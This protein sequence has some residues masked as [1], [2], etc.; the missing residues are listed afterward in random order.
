[1]TQA[2]AEEATGKTD[3]AQG[4]R[5]TGGKP[6]PRQEFKIGNL[7]AG[8]VDFGVPRRVVTA[9]QNAAEV[10]AALSR[11]VPPPGYGT[12]VDR[13]RDRNVVVIEG[14][15][16]LGRY[17]GAL[18]LLREVVQGDVLPISPTTTLEELHTCEY[19]RGRGYYVPEHTARE[20]GP[21]AQFRWNA[22]CSSVR[23]AGA[24]L[25]ITTTGA[26]AYAGALPWQR[27]D[28]GKLLR[29]VLGDSVDA[30]PADVRERIPV[31]WTPTDIVAFGRRL[32]DGSGADEALGVFDLTATAD[33]KE[34]FHDEDR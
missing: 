28:L 2:E 21:E 13:L 8:N 5:T 10:D 26:P 19:E 11:Y 9:L 18:A 12:A 23:T 20:S 25:V 14:R 27:P 1:M 7:Y 3:D 34:W 4:R 30:V 31:D 29:A 33:V 17:T 16:G 15:S 22:V 32:L 24:F 6:A